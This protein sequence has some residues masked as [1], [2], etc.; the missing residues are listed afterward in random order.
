WTNVPGVQMGTSSKVSGYP[1]AITIDLGDA[2]SLTACF[3][4]G[5]GN[6]DS[7]NSNN[8]T[9]GVGEYTY[10]NGSITKMN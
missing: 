1:Y 6:W 3:N 10:S 7:N 5:N 9:F 2:T 8:Y 4:D